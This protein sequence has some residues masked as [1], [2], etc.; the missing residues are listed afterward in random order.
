MRCG[1]VIQR[2]RDFEHLTPPTTLTQVC[3]DGWR[4]F[5]PYAR[6]DSTLGL[7]VP[8]PNDFDSNVVFNILVISRQCA[9]TEELRCRNGQG[10][11][12][13]RERVA[14]G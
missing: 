6:G 14:F 12:G 9:L 1:V 13:L 3:R 11:N 10:R 4:A 8:P 2:W 7:V 5:E